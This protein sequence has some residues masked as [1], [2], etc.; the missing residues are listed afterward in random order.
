MIMRVCGS[1]TGSGEGSGGGDDGS[2][3]DGDDVA[4]SSLFPPPPPPP[5]EPP[6]MSTRLIRFSGPELTAALSPGSSYL[7]HSKTAITIFG[8]STASIVQFAVGSLTSPS[9]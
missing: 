8:P 9:Q 7:S 4:E 1:G 5:P 6:I 3:G 2:S